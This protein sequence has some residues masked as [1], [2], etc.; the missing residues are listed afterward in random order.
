MVKLALKYTYLVMLMG[1]L[2]ACS[3]KIFQKYSFLYIICLSY[4][5]LLYLFIFR[6]K[7]EPFLKMN[8][9]EDDVALMNG[10]PVHS[11]SIN[12]SMIRT[13]IETL[14]N[15]FNNRFKQVVFT[16]VLNAYYAGFIPL[17][18]V[19]K[20]LYYDTLFA[21]QHLAFSFLGCFTMS[22]AFCFPVKYS[23]VLHRASL[24]LGV[25]N[26][27]STRNHPPPLPWNK[28]IIWPFGTYVKF[29][30]DVYRSNSISTCATPA[31]NSHYRFYVSY[32]SR[33][34]ISNRK[35]PS[36]LENKILG[37]SGV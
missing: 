7:I 37:P 35:L 31:N 12:A 19:Y 27:T 25:W 10:F 26:K 4:P 1:L 2:L 36:R 9:P 34:F 20:H 6:L 17:C 18:F 30:G 5:L 3:F 23:D 33:G 21:T 15:D 22:I 14:K 24:H 32:G 29:S 8:S 11:C 28:S 16:S 13:E